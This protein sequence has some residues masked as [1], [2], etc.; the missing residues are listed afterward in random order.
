M[1][2]IAAMQASSNA[3]GRIIAGCGST[4]GAAAAKTSSGKLRAN[5]VR[6]LCETRPEGDKVRATVTT[7]FCCIC[8]KRLSFEAR[9]NSQPVEFIEPASGFVPSDEEPPN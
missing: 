2:G 3:N 6:E 1:N 8:N 7:T 4:P 5:M 9:F